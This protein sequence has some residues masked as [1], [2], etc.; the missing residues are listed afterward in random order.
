[1]FDFAWTEIALIGIVAL[2]AIGPK[3]LPVAI[4]AV[5]AMI[6]KAR[7][8]ASEFQGHVD[9]MVREADLHE[10]RDQFN[11]LRSFNVKDQI[12]KAVDA[13]GSL[14]ATI[15]ETRAQMTEATQNLMQPEMPAQS[16]APFESAPAEITSAEITPAEITSAEI[17]SSDAEHAEIAPVSD[18]H[19]ADAAAAVAHANPAPTAPA[20]PAFI[21][22]TA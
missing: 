18:E 20:P 7:R 15:D 19:V 13:D 5:A 1:M 3:D 10:V 12:A 21:P 4:K 17:T 8:M 22:P 9:E 6:R 16:I 11:Q 2:I 14:R